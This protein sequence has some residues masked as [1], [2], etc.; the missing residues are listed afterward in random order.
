VVRLRATRA[1]ADPEATIHAG[2]QW[3]P[4]SAQQYPYDSQTGTPNDERHKRPVPV[5]AV[6]VQKDFWDYIYICAGLIIAIA[7]LV[8]AVTARIQAKAAKRAIETQMNAERAWILVTDVESPEA[9]YCSETAYSPGIVYRLKVFGHTPV[10]ITSH[11]FRFHPVSKRPGTV[12]PEPDLPPIPDYRSDTR[13]PDIPKME[14]YSL[15]AR[16]LTL[17]AISNPSS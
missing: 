5:A 16:P 10:R 6:T 15:L 3:N 7:T 17:E 14:G 8:V 12:S 4:H 9:L 2:F 13:S 1:P 11:E